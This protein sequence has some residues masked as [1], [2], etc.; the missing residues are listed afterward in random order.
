M[1]LLLNN[2]V[3]ENDTIVSPTIINEIFKPQ[4]I[5]PIGGARFNNEF[6]TLWV[7]NSKWMIRS[8]NIV[9]VLMACPSN[10]VMIKDEYRVCNTNQ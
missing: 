9:E 3:I 10:L 8:L 2:R 6:K 5:F 4:I 1:R 7:F